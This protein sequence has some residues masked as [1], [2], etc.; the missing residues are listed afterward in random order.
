MQ[1]KATKFLLSL[2]LLVISFFTFNMESKAYVNG[3]T[4]G[5]G[6]ASGDVPIPNMIVLEDGINIVGGM[7]QQILIQQLE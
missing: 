5:S 7:H 3:I 4:G 1:K 6:G 2:S